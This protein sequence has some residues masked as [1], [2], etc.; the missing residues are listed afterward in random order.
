MT[1]KEILDIAENRPENLLLVEEHTLIELAEDDFL[2]PALRCAALAEL[3]VRW[4]MSLRSDLSEWIGRLWGA[5]GWRAFSDWYRIEVSWRREVPEGAGCWGD[6]SGLSGFVAGLKPRLCELFATDGFIPVCNGKSAWF[7]PFALVK[8]A[9]GVFWRDGSEVCDTQAK[10]WKANTAEILRGSVYSGIMLSLNCGPE[11]SNGF[12]GASL[13]LPVSLALWRKEGNDFPQ[14]DVFRIVATGAFTVDGKLDDVDVTA[15]Y[16]AFTRA[17]AGDAVMF[18]PIDSSAESRDERRYVPIDRGIEI[19]RM[20]EAIAAE[21]EK[22]ALA[23]ITRD[24]AL[25][26]LPKMNAFVDRENLSGWSD[27]ARRLETLRG[28]VNR[29]RDSVEYLEYLSLLATACCHA[30]MTNESRATVDEALRFAH[31]K[32]CKAMALRLQLTAAVDAQDFGEFEEF[33]V[34]ADG[35]DASLASFDGPER[36]DLMMRYHG[37]LA[38]AQA[39][40]VVYGLGDCSEKRAIAEAYLAL[41]F[42]SRIANRADEL[43]RAEAES[44]VA[45]DLNYVHLMSALFSPGSAEEDTAYREAVAQLDNLDGGSRENNRYFQLRQRSLAY[46]NRWRNNGGIPSFVS[47][48][49]VRLPANQAEGWQVM[50]NRCHLGAL[51]AAA[52]DVD[53]ALSCFREGDAALPLDRCWAP[54]F[55]SIR[56]AFLAQAALSLNAL[57]RVNEAKRY[58]ELLKLAFDMAVESTLFKSIRAERWLNAVERKDDP[59]TL[60][61]FYY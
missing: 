29:F 32:G 7:I 27:V 45:Q 38:Q 26:R 3:V 41:D 40:G 34:L 53:E 11:F 42:A 36:D 43:H 16:N 56:T 22:R 19:S 30:G 10:D 12:S 18:A 58:E 57:G 28:G 61:A 25:R 52:G 20:R 50:A 60:P 51:A 37:T 47:R 4:C 8:N 55:V 39:W 15:K 23:L 21:I 49:S 46:Y 17:F 59:R 5:S 6:P 24:Y 14:Y 1:E 33:N 2:R 13:M 48:L 31:A 44:N 35:L 9:A 54:V